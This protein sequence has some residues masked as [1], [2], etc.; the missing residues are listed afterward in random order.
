MDVSAPSD[1]RRGATP[2]IYCLVDQ[3]ARVIDVSS[4]THIL[5][6]WNED[7]RQSALDEWVHP[8]DVRTV[9]ETLA[10]ASGGDPTPSVGVRIRGHADEWIR[11]RLVVNPPMAREPALY[12]IAIHLLDFATEPADLRALRLEGHLW[13]IALEVQAAGLGG[14]PGHHETWWADPELAGLS[15]RQAEILR[16]IVRGERPHDIARE[17]VITESTV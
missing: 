11:A 14:Q 16:R 13:R 6:G 5:L 4:N 8:R 1:D 3:S 2:V 15:A 7:Q 10:S 9:Q 17:L 12:V